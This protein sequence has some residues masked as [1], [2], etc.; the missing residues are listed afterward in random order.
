LTG[1]AAPDIAAPSLLTPA[2]APTL[3]GMQFLNANPHPKIRGQDPLP[4]IV[5]Y[6]V[7]NNP[8]LWHT[9]IPTFAQ[10]RYQNIY[11]GIDLLYDGSRG[12]LEYDFLVAPGSDP[13]QIHLSFS[14]VQGLSLD[15]QGELLLHLPNGSLPEAAPQVYQVI[16]GRR[17]QVASSYSLQGAAKVGFALG[18]Y[19]A[20][21]PLVIDPAVL[22]ATYLGG[23]KNDYSSG[24]A[25]DSQG[26]VYITGATDSTNFPTQNPLQAAFGGGRSDAFVTRV[27]AGGTALLYSTY[28]GGSGADWG[29][30]IAVDGAG[31]AYVTGGVSS[32]NFPLQH[33][34]QASESGTANAFVTKVNATGSALIYSTYLGGSTYDVASGIALD[35]AG[36]AYVT[37]VTHSSNFPTQ[38]ALYSTYGGG[39][40]AF[41]TKLNA[42][43]SALV[44][45]TYLG[46]SRSD[47]GTGITVDSQGNAYITGSTSSTNFPPHNALYAS[48]R[49]G[50]D[51]FVAE[52]LARGNALASSSYLGGNGNDEGTSIAVAST[53]NSIYVAGATTSSNFPTVH[54][55][56][57]YGG[58]KKAFCCK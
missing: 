12:S 25:M 50:V 22:F 28:L 44:Y 37:G 20:S 40:D 13:S 45:S 32:T 41:V 57:G 49:G 18:A 30:G 21:Q 16:N 51:A 11:P 46:G 33:A 3:V 35:S 23:S 52:I 8:A 24:L 36:D 4:G 7:G 54:P 47:W 48:N 15:A 5:N 1:P 26:N 31:N 6:L 27:N 14:G 56:Q 42:A 43:G 34:L 39:G 58:G 17:Q 29:T 9:N 55:I 53:D 19:D 10:V 2:A 38:N